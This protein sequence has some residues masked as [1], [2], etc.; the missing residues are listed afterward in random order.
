MLFYFFLKEER[1]FIRFFFQVELDLENET[2][3]KCTVY[4][5]VQKIGTY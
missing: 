4:Q 3:N 5:N 2:T 1:G